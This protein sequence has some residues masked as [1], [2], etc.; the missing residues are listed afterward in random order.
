MLRSLQTTNPENHD[1]ILKELV[2]FWI[3]EMKRPDGVELDEQ[4]LREALIHRLQAKPEKPA[5]RK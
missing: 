4:T 3:K 1:M 2:D 5:E